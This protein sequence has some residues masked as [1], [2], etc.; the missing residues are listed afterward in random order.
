MVYLTY[1]QSAV[2]G[3]MLENHLR[4]LLNPIELNHK[5]LMYKDE[6]DLIMQLWCC[7]KETTAP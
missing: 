1:F 5:K 4:H 7:K 3:L 2:Y 6:L